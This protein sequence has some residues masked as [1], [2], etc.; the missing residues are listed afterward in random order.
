MEP[1][2]SH[3]LFDYFGNDTAGK[4]YCSDVL[5]FNIDVSFTNLR[6][7]RAVIGIWLDLV[8]LILAGPN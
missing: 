8:S 4:N 6:T 5:A 7:K 2:H 1:E 3:E